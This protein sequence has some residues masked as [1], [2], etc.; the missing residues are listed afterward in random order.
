MGRQLQKIA[1]SIFFLIA[2]TDIAAGQT[3]VIQANSVSLLLGIPVP[4]GANVYL[5]SYYC[6]GSP[7]CTPDGG[8]GLFV[9]TGAACPGGF[10]P[11]TDATS[12]M[13]T[14]SALSARI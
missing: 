10:L 3:A 6:T 2:L 5:S 4:A 14:T 11:I 7:P 8:E 9:N 1:M 12:R 13:Q